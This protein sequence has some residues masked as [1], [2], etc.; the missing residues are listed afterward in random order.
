MKANPEPIIFQRRPESPYWQAAIKLPGRPRR[1][2][3][4]T[5]LRDYFALAEWERICLLHIKRQ[6]EAGNLFPFPK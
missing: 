1:L 6:A 5:G 4:S 2:R 3:R